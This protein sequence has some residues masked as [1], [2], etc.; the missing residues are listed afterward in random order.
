METLLTPHFL[1]PVPNQLGR[2]TMLETFLSPKKEKMATDNKCVLCDVT[3]YTQNNNKHL[4]T[5]KSDVMGK[6]LWCGAE[7]AHTHAHTCTV[8]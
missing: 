2:V 5:Q 7:H 4:N 6:G 3:S 8:G 1:C